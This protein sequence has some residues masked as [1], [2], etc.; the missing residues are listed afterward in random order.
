MNTTYLEAICRVLEKEAEYPSDELLIR[1]VKIQ[2]IGQSISSALTGCHARCP[3][4][5][6]PII[7][8][9]RSFQIQIDEFKATLPGY[10]Q[11][12]SMPLCL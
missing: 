3:F 4:S 2:Q 10:L 6:V 12:N 9:V 7:M 11:A 1:L 8:V 5:P